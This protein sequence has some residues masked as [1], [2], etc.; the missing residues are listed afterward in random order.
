[1]ISS[2]GEGLEG[3]GRDLNEEEAEVQEGKGRREMAVGGRE[4]GTK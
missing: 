3:G 4:E 2:H 1:M